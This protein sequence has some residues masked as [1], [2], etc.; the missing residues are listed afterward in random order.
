MEK[1]KDTNLIPLKKRGSQH[2]ITNSIGSVGVASTAAT[3][4]VTGKSGKSCNDKNGNGLVIIS[5]EHISFNQAAKD[6]RVAR[7]RGQSTNSMNSVSPFL[8]EASQT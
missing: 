4:G 5:K 6:A 2:R 1:E 3:G 8:Q 7:L